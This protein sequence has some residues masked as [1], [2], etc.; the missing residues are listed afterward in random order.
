MNKEDKTF[1][2]GIILAAVIIAFAVYSMFSKDGTNNSYRIKVNTNGGVPY[3]WSYKV[4]DES[5]VEIKQTS[6]ALNNLDGGPVEVYFDIKPIKKGNTI[7]TLEYK[8]IRDQH[9]E[10]KEVYE[11]EITDELKMTVKKQK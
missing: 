1:I 11:I 6:K 3:S 9:I 8:D 7:L 5:L 4:E 10:E 2:A